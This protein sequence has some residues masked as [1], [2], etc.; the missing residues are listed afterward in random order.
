[1]YLV[2]PVWSVDS[3]NENIIR[4]RSTLKK[5]AKW[6]KSSTRCYRKLIK[7]TDI[8]THYDHDE[9]IDYSITSTCLNFPFPIEK[10]LDN[11]PYPNF[12]ED[13]Y[14]YFVQ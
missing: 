1:M 8:S 4:K 2:S 9:E 12:D 5:G 3:R 6:S 14:L 13:A 10:Y 7:N 11:E